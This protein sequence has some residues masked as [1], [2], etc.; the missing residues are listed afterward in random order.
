MRNGPARGPFPAVR[1]RRGV[2]VCRR[3]VHHGLRAGGH[4]AG[5]QGLGDLPAAGY[6][7]LSIA[8]DVFFLAKDFQRLEV[9]ND[10]FASAFYFL[11]PSLVLIVF[12]Q[13]FSRRPGRI[14]FR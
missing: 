11:L 12:Y 5:P 6:T 7:V 4:E 1:L 10:I 8:W 13:P 3:G 14:S 2:Q 9:G